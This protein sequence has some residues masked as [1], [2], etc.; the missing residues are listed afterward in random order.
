MATVIAF[1]VQSLSCVQLLVTTGTEAHQPSLSFT[2]CYSFLRLLSMV[3]MPSIHLIL[4]LHLLLLPSVIPRIRVFSN[5][6]ILHIR[7]P[8]FRASAS[9]SVLSVNSQDSFRIDWFD[10]L[11]IQRTVKSPLAPQFKSIN[12]SMQQPSLWPNSHRRT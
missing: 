12:S 8:I 9:V 5:E 6:L 1:V 4:H 7:W 2:T 11:I 10:L 3:L